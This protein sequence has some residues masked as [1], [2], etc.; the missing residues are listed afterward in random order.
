MDLDVEEIFVDEL[1]VDLRCPVCLSVLK[2]PCQTSCGHR[3]CSQCIENIKKNSPNPVCPID[4]QRIEDGVFPDMAAKMQIKKLKVHCTHVKKGCTWIG[5]M[6]DKETHLRVCFHSVRICPLCSVSLNASEF[7]QHKGVC[8]RRLCVCEYCRKELPFSELGIHYNHC[9]LYLVICP[10][11]CDEGLRIP[12]QSVA[13]HCRDYCPL[14]AI[15][16]KLEALG[17][18]ESIPRNKMEPHLQSCAIKHVSRLAAIVLEQ[19]QEIETL[20]KTLESHENNLKD[21]AITCYPSH[22]QF[23]WRINDIVDKVRKAQI[24]SDT[25]TSI[26]YS[27]AFFTAEAGYKLCLCIYPAGDN[28]QGCM[29]LFFVVMKGPFDEI[30]SWPFQKRVCLQLI[31][32]RPGHGHILKEIIPDPR[33]H[34]FK[35]PEN[36]KN[37]GYGYPRFI[38]L[39][40]LIGENSDFV[41]NGAIFIRA[42]VYN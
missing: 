37:V 39:Q 42:I 28:N 35:R 38:P 19:K 26:V 24:C 18:R 14:E 4:R 3:F 31:N 2:D 11:K 7:E 10:N 17:C 27:P 21:L 6:S 20:R 16:C 23:T 40:K 32:C 8:P 25:S 5:D 41:A 29:S 1:P 15:T 22:G 33:L 36:D 9:D 13:V 34:Y 30:L 12:R